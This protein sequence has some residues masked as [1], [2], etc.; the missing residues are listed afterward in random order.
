MYTW[1]DLAASHVRLIDRESLA[2]LG[3]IHS[4]CL[5]QRLNDDLYNYSTSVCSER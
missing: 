3:A 1:S 2:F 4:R 5:P